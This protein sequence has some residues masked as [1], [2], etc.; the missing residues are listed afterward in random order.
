MN[1]RCRHNYVS[2][3]RI[4]TC[5]IATQARKHPQ[6]SQLQPLSCRAPRRATMT[7]PAHALNEKQAVVKKKRASAAQAP[8]PTK[9]RRSVEATDLAHRSP[10]LVPWTRSRT[11]ICRFGFWI[12]DLGGVCSRLRLV[13]AGWCRGK[14]HCR[15]EAQQ[16][17]TLHLHCV[18]YVPRGVLELLPSYGSYPGPQKPL[19]DAES[20]KRRRESETHTDIADRA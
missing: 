18:C 15:T 16:R 13:Q 8:V 17:G 19:R 4:S 11:D 1:I 5:T 6:L 20:Q 7:T 12:A 14:L 10:Q 3:A 2:I 9:T